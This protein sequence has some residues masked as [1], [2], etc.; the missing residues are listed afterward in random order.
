MEKV[1]DTHKDNIKVRN[2]EIE[3]K[4]RIVVNNPSLTTL[5]IK[6][7]LRYFSKRFSYQKEKLD[8]VNSCSYTKTSTSRLKK[9]KQIFDADKGHCNSPKQFKKSKVSLKNSR[10]NNILNHFLDKSYRCLKMKKRSN[11]SSSYRLTTSGQGNSIRK[12]KLVNL[13]LRSRPGQSIDK[14]SNSKTLKII[15]KL[16]STKNTEPDDNKSSLFDSRVQFMKKKS[17][18]LR[19]FEFLKQ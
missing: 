12:I 17:A 2:K 7:N 10:T 14:I 19:L 8:L 9:K 4:F 16:P 3:Q 11:K 1:L 15:R 13:T 18:N 6:N 5:Q